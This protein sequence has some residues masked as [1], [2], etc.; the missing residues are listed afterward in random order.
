MVASK[1]EERKLFTN[2]VRTQCTMAMFKKFYESATPITA[3]EMENNTLKLAG[4]IQ[5]TGEL[6]FSPIVPNT[7]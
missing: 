5:S 4:P 7:A 6:E 3:E 1:A 2:T